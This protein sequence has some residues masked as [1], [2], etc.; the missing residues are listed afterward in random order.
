[1]K[2][3]L[4]IILSLFLTSLSV[5]AVGVDCWEEYTTTN[6]APTSSDLRTAITN[7]GGSAILVGTRA[8]VAGYEA[9]VAASSTNPNV[10]NAATQFYTLTTN[11]PTTWKSFIYGNSQYGA[12]VGRERTYDIHYVHTYCVTDSSSG[13]SGSGGAT[14]SVNFII[15]AT[16]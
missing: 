11:L 3:S 10:S 15:K 9:A 13:S 8:S 12:G 1:M 2:K 7:A 16:S 6:T 5:H 4:L 14:G